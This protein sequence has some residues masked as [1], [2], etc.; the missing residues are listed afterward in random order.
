MRFQFSA[1]DMV[2]RFDGLR[3]Y[4]RQTST[5]GADFLHYLRKKFPFPIKAIQVDGG[6]EFR[7]QFEEASR[8]R[9]ILL[10]EL[11][12]NSPKLNGRVERANRTLREFYEVYDVHLNLEGHNRLLEEWAYTYNN[13]IRP[14]QALDYLKP[15]KS[16]H[17]WKQNKKSQVSL[18]AW[19]HSCA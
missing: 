5:A 13:Y 18:L 4:K 7:D 6:S 1:R 2:V 14:H 9:D 19:P 15:H 11:P 12:P 16:Y 3:A 17:R 10:F 8:R